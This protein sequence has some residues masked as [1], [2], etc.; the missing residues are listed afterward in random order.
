MELL[1][2]TMKMNRRSATGLVGIAGVALLFLT[3]GAPSASADTAS[4][5]LNVCNTPVVCNSGTVNLNL[6][7]SSIEVTVT[8][9]SGFGIFGSGGAFGF[10]VVGST[11]GLTI[12]G[13]APGTFFQDG[14]NQQMD[15]FGQFEFLID[16]PAASSSSSSL[17]FTVSRTGGFNSVFQLVEANAAGATFAAHVIALNQPTPNTGFAAVPE[18]TSMLL[19]GAGLLG[20]GLTARRLRKKG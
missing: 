11:A 3:M 5:N 8:M 4:F 10:N 16:G 19:L 6:V 14:T 12:T 17:V 9:N 2:L 20:V 7:G 15:G 13:I 18:P 1:M